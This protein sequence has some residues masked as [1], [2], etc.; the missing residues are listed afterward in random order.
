MKSLRLATTSSHKLRESREIL[1][2]HGFEVRG[3]EG[4]A[5]DVIEDGATFEANALKKA[6]AL[7]AATGEPAVADD[8]GLCVDALG[9][10]PGVHSARYAGASGEDRDAA[11]RKKLLAAL[12]QVPDAQRTARF[13]CALAYATPAGASWT[14]RG[15]VE[16]VITRK[17]RGAGGFGYD[18]LFFL[19]DFACT[20]AE[21]GSAEKHAVSHRGRAWAA[22]LA[23]LERADA[24]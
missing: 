13:V 10:E 24:P 3:L 17:E 21:L 15:E 1:A 23:R 16:G 20:A 8:S 14:V 2:P 18:S 12:A 22:F 9:G 4:L 19:P 7:A 6:H 5:F 11:N